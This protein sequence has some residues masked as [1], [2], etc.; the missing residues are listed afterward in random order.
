MR[1]V[2]LVVSLAV[3]G[4]RAAPAEEVAAPVERT[5]AP[6]M[7]TPTR[8][9]SEAPASRGAGSATEA[10]A[11]P[12]DAEARVYEEDAPRSADPVEP[13]ASG[14]PA[15]TCCRTCRR[16]KACGDSCIAADKR[17]DVGPGC[18]CDG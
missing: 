1:R 16:G 6:P 10:G 11:R 12:G 7:P 9:A 18:A 5:A 4:C 14:A 15:R 13:P 2:W 17:C 8:E 3:C